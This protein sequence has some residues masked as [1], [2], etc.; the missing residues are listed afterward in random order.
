MRGRIHTAALVVVLTAGLAGC[1]GGSKPA[2]TKTSP[3]NVA[4]QALAY[5]RC[6]RAHG[7]DV[8]DP[9][10]NNPGISLPKS[11]AGGQSVQAALQACRDQAPPKL[12]TGNDAGA[13]DHDLAVARCLRAHGVNVPDPQPGQPLNITG[14]LNDE[15]VKQAIAACEKTPATSGGGG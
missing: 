4:D 9:D 1:G 15:K 11:S 13:Q 3:L 6:L 5:A 12:F 2:A 8:P 14:S 7:L 10:P